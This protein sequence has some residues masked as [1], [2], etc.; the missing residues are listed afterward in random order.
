MT[1]LFCD[2]CSAGVLCCGCHQGAEG[3]LCELPGK[4]NATA[5]ATGISEDAGGDDLAEGLQHALQ[6]LLIHRHWQ[7][8]DVQVGGI[9]LLLL[10]MER[11]FRKL[12]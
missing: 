12:S 2:L 4:A 3:G 8:G 5:G 7:V 11:P 10:K 6:F 1:M 9:L